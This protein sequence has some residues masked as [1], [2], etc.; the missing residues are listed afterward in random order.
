MPRTGL[1]RAPAAP[2]A[3]VTSSAGPGKDGAGPATAHYCIDFGW[4]SAPL[5]RRQLLTWR[6]SGDLYLGDLLVAVVEDE[7]GVRRL[8][9]GW[10]E[11]CE[12][13]EGLGWLAQRLEGCR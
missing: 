3:R 10:V 5:G 2:A 6:S 7:V 11:H 12:T 8:L 4:W 1:T 13:R 9:E